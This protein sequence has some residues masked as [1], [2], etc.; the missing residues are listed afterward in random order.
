MWKSSHFTAKTAKQ[1]PTHGILFLFSVASLFFIAFWCC[2]LNLCGGKIQSVV[3][4]CNLKLK[5]LQPATGFVVE[6]S[7]LGA[8]FL[9]T[10]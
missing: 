9:T 8:H 1:K 4:F 10:H 2:N 5:L 7:C 3:F 6:S